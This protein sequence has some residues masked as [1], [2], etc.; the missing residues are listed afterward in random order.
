MLNVLIVE[1]EPL[2]L[3][4]IKTLLQNSSH[5]L[6]LCQTA[7][8]GC[9]ALEIIEQEKPDIVITD[10]KMPK[11][12]G[13]ELIR[14]CREQYGELPVFIILTNYEEFQLAK[15]A[16]TLGVVD[17]LVKLELTGE[18]LDNSLLLA[19]RRIEELAPQK[20]QP[21]PAR[22]LQYYK[23]RFFIRL[24]NNL[25]ENEE[26]FRLE[27][28][29]LGISFEGF[30]WLV[31]CYIELSGPRLSELSSR[32]QMDLFGSSLDMIRNILPRYLSCYCIPLDIR[33]LAVI[34]LF[35]DEQYK[36]WQHL[37]QTALDNAAS[38]LN[39]YY[40]AEM[41]GACGTVVTHPLSVHESFQSARQLFARADRKQAFLFPDI[42]DPSAFE[43]HMFNMSL[44]KDSIVKAYEEYDSEKLTEIVEAIAGLFAD[45]PDHYI[46]AMDAASNI[47][48]LS[49]SLISD[50]E[51]LVSD[52]F[53]SSPSGYRCLYSLT[54]AGQVMDWLRT[55]CSGLCRFFDERKKDY[56]NHIVSGVRQYIQTHLQE[57]L[58]LNE[59]AAAFG[60]SP[61]YLSLLFKKYSDCG[62]NEYVTQMKIGKA[63]E[64]IQEE[65]LKIYEIADQLGFEN[66]FYFSKVFKKV[67]GC[68]PREYQYQCLDTKR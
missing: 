38:M 43:D 15:E 12:D 3:I 20:P 4:G 45:H 52:I 46:Q 36:D 53:S 40:G 34:F 64:L 16:L 30:P 10:I 1:D 65:H 56:K 25:F 33:H 58:S 19:I 62:F 13:L 39:S 67:E 21:E 57:K 41:T 6:R 44:F 59:V 50:G 24:L 2:V 61:S 7:S 31:T 63:K 54:S 5:K 68:S 14:R 28:K 17:Y 42:A 9:A 11:M 35:T 32:Q 27:T 51:S 48:Y 23:E 55:L 49:I 22:F 29:D 37:L 47:L 18:A 8:N 60:I 66:A 26:Q